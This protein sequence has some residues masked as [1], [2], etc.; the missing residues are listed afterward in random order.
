MIIDYI[1]LNNFLSHRDTLIR[2]EK[3][4]NIIYGKNG[5]GKSSI[6]DAIRF[7]LF[8]EKRGDKIAELV[9]SGTNGC[10][11]TI[12]FRLG[13]KYYQVFRSMGL[14]KSGVTQRNSWIKLDD[15]MI[16]ETSEGVTEEIRSGLGIPKDTFLNSVFVRQGEMDA[17][18][19]ETAKKREELFSKIIG[20]DILSE[21]AQK[22]KQIRDR[23]RMAEAQ[24]GSLPD[25]IERMTAEI[26]E[27]RERVEGYSQALQ[28]VNEREGKAKARV[29]EVEAVRNQAIE[30]KSRH[31][32]LVTTVTE[33]RQRLESLRRG[34]SEKEQNLKNISF[35]RDEKEKIE[36]DPVFV[37]RKEISAYF[38]LRDE[39]RALEVTLKHLGESVEDYTRE[40]VKLEGLAE[41]HRQFEE[42][43]KKLREMDEKVRSFQK[44]RAVKGDLEADLKKN[45]SKVE[46][47]SA[48]VS[49][50][51]FRDLQG[52]DRNR[53]N[54]EIRDMEEKLREY[55]GD[56]KTIKERI[57]NLSRRRTELRKNKDTL[58]DNRECPVCGTELD[59][60]HLREIHITYENEEKE[61]SEQINQNAGMVSE[62]NAKYSEFEKK[63][64]RLRR[65]DVE[66]LLRS[67]EERERIHSA[68]EETRRKLS[69]IDRRIGE[70]PNLEEEYETFRKSLDS[71]KE[72]EN[73]YHS[74][75]YSLG[76]INIEDIRERHD[77]TRIEADS[78]KTA[79]RE[80]SETI[81]FVPDPSDREKADELVSSYERIRSAED[82]Y[83]R[84]NTELQSEKS[85]AEQTNS[86]LE[87]KVREA[88]S[89]KD[90][91]E[92]MRNATTKYNEAQQEYSEIR[93]NRAVLN[94]RIRKGRE[95]LERMDRERELLEADA[96]KLA[97]L[98]DAS[99]K[100]ERIRGSF[101]RGG[102]Q[103][104]I[105]K[106]SSVAI[107]NMTRNYLSSFNFDFDDV[108]IDE[109]FDIR[110]INNGVEEALDS[111]SGGERISLAIA[112]RL[113][114]AKYLTGRVSTVIMDEPTNFL[115]EDRRNNLKDIIQ[116]SLKDENMV[117]QMIMITHHAE[118]TSAAD[119]SLEVTKS[120]G[121]SEVRQG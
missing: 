5:A 85:T 54:S 95:D 109:N 52:Y 22:I 100:L 21:S 108:R 66:K 91:G 18:I 3:G 89:M 17:L 10:S 111:L 70:T 6:V 105:R 46:E 113:A 30:R 93:Q 59:E 36:K 102:I 44:D 50:E 73:R 26:R 41:S 79:M 7:A 68:M 87:K 53:L 37:N 2:F 86:E 15:L 60:V 35:S 29:D 90:A 96:G 99:S 74:I 45:M 32:T 103:A 84:L 57:G 25:K 20:I 121:L 14:G 116:Y 115:D 83:N 110:V 76:K 55:E 4:V 63:L 71:L 101:E 88:E 67:M 16:A 80:I 69:E 47:L 120:S 39:A 104:L 72:L 77:R 112:V 58:G 107:N 49:R 82:R 40:K 94:E 81:G 27:V 43:D 34:I 92:E 119:L 114:I 75:S 42:A 13:D 28:S 64:E 19:S 98:K 117:Q 61:L 78:K 106:D 24:Y 38:R 9:R 8:G 97:K 33:L 48:C 1:Q 23:L 65:E 118:L 51:E 31:D 11:V 12:G 56:R 62:L